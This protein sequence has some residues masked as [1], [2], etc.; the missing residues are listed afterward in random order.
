MRGDVKTYF[1][2]SYAPGEDRPWVRR[3]HSD[4]ERELRI[5][6]GPYAGGAMAAP[7][8]DPVRVAATAPAM[9]A[10]ISDRYLRDLGCGRQW[11]IFAERSRPDAGARDHCL[12]PIR[13]RPLRGPLPDAV[14]PMPDFWASV[15]PEPYRTS[16]LYELMRTHQLRDEGGYY[17]MVRRIAEQVFAAERV[18]LRQ[19]DPAAAAAVR[20][21]F[22]SQ[23]PGDD[24]RAGAAA[25]AERPRTVAISYVGADQPWAEWIGNLLRDNDY[26]VELIRWNAGRSERLTEAVDRAR[27]TGDRVIAVL[28]HNYVAPHRAPI[29]E[30]DPDWQSVLAPDEDEHEELIRVQI[31]RE[32]LPGGLGERVI[33][34]YGLEAGVIRELLNA[35]RRRSA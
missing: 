9:V 11:A 28:S 15:T 21:A 4:L 5:R 34:L 3:F 20:P 26:E 32:P 16:G 35:V 22:G 8:A 12:I 6:Q 2:T 13:W 25:P 17:G 31:D 14:R 18:R 10:L 19:L 7:P 24:R 29:R 27:R 33:R 1:F 23:E 30:E